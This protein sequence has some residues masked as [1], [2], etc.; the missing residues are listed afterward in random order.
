MNYFCCQ[1]LLT[2]FP[3][4]NHFE[5]SLNVSNLKIIKQSSIGPFCTNVREHSLGGSITVQLTSCLFCLDSAALL[6]SNE[7]KFYLLGQIQTSQTGGQI[8][9]DSSPTLTIYFRYQPEVVFHLFQ[10]FVNCED[11]ADAVGAAAAA[12]SAPDHGSDD[13]SR[14]ARA[15]PLRWG[16]RGGGQVT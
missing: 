4:S 10:Q 14:Y 2:T 1:N 13:L 15:S 5:A 6:M 12:G 7:Q 11:G 9:N 8:K 3:I 16:K